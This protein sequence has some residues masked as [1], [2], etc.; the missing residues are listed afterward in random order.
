METMG[1]LTLFPQGGTAHQGDLVALE[2]VLCGLPSRSIKV[3]DFWDGGKEGRQQKEEIGR[4]RREKAIPPGIG[5]TAS[6]TRERE[7]RC[8]HH[9]LNLHHHWAASITSKPVC[10]RHVT[11]AVHL[12]ANPPDNPERWDPYQHPRFKD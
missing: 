11:S 10:A 9:H 5:K 4:R 1:I 7:Y 8:L 12:T 3:S 2:C 6:L